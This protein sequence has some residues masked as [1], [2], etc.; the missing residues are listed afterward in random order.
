MSVNNTPTALI[1]DDTPLMLDLLAKHLG[2]AKYHIISAKDGQ[3]AIQLAEDAQPDIILL[4]VMMPD[5]NGF[6]VCKQLKDNEATKDIPV[7]FTTALSDIDDK[8]RGFEVGAVDYV[9]KPFNGREVLAR[10]ATHLTI[11]N[12]QKKLQAEVAERRKA[13]EALRQ[14]TAELRTRNEELDAFARTVA[15]DL[16][17]PLGAINGIANILV[18]DYVDMS[19]ERLEEYLQAIVRGSRKATNIVD[20]LLILASV[21]QHDVNPVPLDMAAI[22]DEAQQ[23]LFDMINENQAQITQPEH[24][25][26]ALG[27]APWIE[28]VWANYISN[29]IKYG[30]SPPHIELG[31]TPQSNGTVCFWI[32]DNGAGL[33]PEEQARLFTPFTRLS[34]ARAQ[35]HGLGLSI[36]RRIIE[37][38]GG[39]VGVE[40]KGVPGQGSTFS[41]TLTAA[42]DSNRRVARQTV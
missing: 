37:K 26:V 42:A 32:K 7:I 3:T 15:H 30:N 35:G 40:S 19:P 1:V 16:Q 21:R 27:Y 38:L 9:T 2:R 10:V 33:T 12:L 13:E 5:M 25:P 23:R 18:A 29:A 4:D 41:F 36:V 17:N 22:V 24:W 8:V 6:E 14:Y 11:R 39:T 20:E 31:A 34:E 28:E